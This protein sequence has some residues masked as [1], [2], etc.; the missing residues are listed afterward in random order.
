M[1]TAFEHELSTGLREEADGVHLSRDVLAAAR[2]R[3]RRRTVVTRAASGAGTVGVA[4]AVTTAMALN[5]PVA[6]A[7]APGST[8]PAASATVRLDAATVSARLT[9]ALLAPDESVHHVTFRTTLGGKSSRSDLWEDLTSGAIRYGGRK[10]PGAP[11]MELGTERRGDLQTTTTLD[12]DRRTYSRE[13][14]RI[15]TT[16]APPRDGGPLGDFSPEGLKKA[17]AEGTWKLVGEE[18]LD[19][20]PT[21][22]L[23]VTT[24]ARYDC[25]YDLWVDATSYQFVR[26][27]VVQET[28]LG[29]MRYVEDWQYLPRTKAN[30]A[31]LKLTIPKGYHEAPVDNTPTSAGGRG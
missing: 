26:R 18:K 11:L 3:H 19:G 20:R 9:K 29:R 6:A 17:L 10:V 1:S 31:K 21:V 16:V 27:V 15:D 13:E 5:G 30:L 14:Y 22:H 7:P 24:Q 8:P 23:R 25:H 4:G 12:R 2:A 28:D